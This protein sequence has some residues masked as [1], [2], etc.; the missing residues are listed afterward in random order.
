MMIKSKFAPPK[1]KYSELGLHDIQLKSMKITNQ[2]LQGPGLEQES[3]QAEDDNLSGKI[4]YSRP[5]KML[6]K[7]LLTIDEKERIT[8]TE[9]LK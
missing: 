2:M 4:S 9:V 1:K 6:I 7:E 3:K 8:A 5:A